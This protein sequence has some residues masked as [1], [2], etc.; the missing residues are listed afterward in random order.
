MSRIVESPFDKN[1]VIIA[2]GRKKRPFQEKI[3]CP[4]CIGAPEVPHEV[5]SVI[6]LP[7]KFPSLSMNYENG[8]GICEVVL[9][10]S[11]HN[12]PLT[13]QD[14][15][16][17]VSVVKHWQKRYLEIIQMYPELKY[18]FFFENYGKEIGVS[19]EHPHGQMYCFPMIPKVI[20][21]K[22]DAMKSDC[23]YCAS[24]LL[25][26]ENETFKIEASPFAKWPFEL[27]LLPKT[28]IS[29][30]QEMDEK[31]IYDLAIVMKIAFNLLHMKFGEKTPYIF[32]VFQTFHDDTSKVFHLHFELISPYITSTRLKYRAGIETA[33]GIFINSID[34]VDFRE[35]MYNLVQEMDIYGDS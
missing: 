25:I 32:S 33:L 4:F 8:K 17:I 13:E 9:Y 35:E 28:H 22:Y 2:S 3:V 12:I 19:L 31:M 14:N 7:N 29:S 18:T 23:H 15:T 26:F 24:N 30:I 34:P 21:E 27:L 10:S 16:F 20:K 6:S 5:T 11:D 1:H